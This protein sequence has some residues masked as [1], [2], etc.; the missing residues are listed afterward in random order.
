MRIVLLR[1]IIVVIALGVSL[2]ILNYLGY[3][4]ATP[5]P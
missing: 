2:V 3:Q 1:V 5:L 4:L